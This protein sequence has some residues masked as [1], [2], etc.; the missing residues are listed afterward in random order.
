M[1]RELAGFA[2]RHGDAALAAALTGIAL[3]QALISEGSADYKLAQGGLAILLGTC[4]ARRVRAP[5][6]LLGMLLAITIVAAVVPRPLGQIN[7]TGLFAI[8]L[9]AVYSAAA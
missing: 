4:A 2:R 7:N 1:R 6:L 5:L 9:L 3:F 8:L